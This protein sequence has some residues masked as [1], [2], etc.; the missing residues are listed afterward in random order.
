MLEPKARAFNNIPQKKA[1]A[2]LDCPANDGQYKSHYLTTQSSKNFF[3]WRV[4]RSSKTGS[5]SIRASVDGENYLPLTPQ[6]HK[7]F[8]FP[9]G[10]KPGYE[11]LQF[12][13][14]KSIVSERTVVIQLEFETEFGTIVQCADMIVQKT[15][16]IKPEKCAQTCRNGG[17][18]QN[19]VCKCGKMF[20]GEFCEER[21]KS[22][23]L[24]LPI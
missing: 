5:C 2:R 23:S 14:P 13:L 16:V 1:A 12:N 6:G 20:T 17:V 24:L 19:A 15:S 7:N 18:C 11:Q 3:E 22:P 4:K 9:C 21:G 8:K 10:R